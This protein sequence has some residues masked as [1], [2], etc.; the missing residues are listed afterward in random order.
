MEDR[1][2]LTSDPKLFHQRKEERGGHLCIL[3]LATDTQEGNCSTV[4]RL[5]FRGVCWDQDSGFKTLYRVSRCTAL[6]SPFCPQS[7]ESQECEG[8]SGG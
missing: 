7:K 5:K 6:R 8:V 3:R 2:P 1:G 4:L